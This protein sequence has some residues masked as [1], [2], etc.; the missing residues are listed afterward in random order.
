MFIPKSLAL[1][2]LFFCPFTFFTYTLP[3]QSNFHWLIS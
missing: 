1:A 3:L 2:G